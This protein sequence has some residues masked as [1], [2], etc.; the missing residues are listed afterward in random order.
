MKP[1]TRLV[2]KYRS[3][4]L[5]KAFPALRATSH[6]LSHLTLEEKCRL[7]QLAKNRE[8]V[9][10]IGSY[11]G[12]STCC[13]GAAL[14]G[15]D[16]GRIICVDTWNNDAMTEGNRDT[17]QEFLD[18]TKSY[19]DHIVP[20]RGYSTDVVC[21]VAANTG[22]ID[23]L[24][25]DGD[26]TYEGVKADWEAYKVFLRSG[27][28]VVLHDWGW[29]EGV[30]KVVEEDVKPVVESFQTLPNLWWGVIK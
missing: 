28:V 29:A 9:L 21:E 17:W 25:I 5:E 27:S 13:F 6:I 22:F 14:N 24:F 16:S 4:Q 20:I 8:H 26:H 10:E 7:Y 3:H 15:A 11:V 18:N 19:K 2:E 1:L 30:K 12:A 23:L